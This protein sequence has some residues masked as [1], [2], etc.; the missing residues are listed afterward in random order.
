MPPRV[1]AA[2]FRAAALIPGVTVVPN[3]VDVAGRPGVAVAMA[4]RTGGEEWVFSKDTFKFLGELDIAH[5]KVVGGSAILQR[6]FVDHVGQL[7]HHG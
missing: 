5:G 3:A 2:L 7:P 1:S 6:A 4:D